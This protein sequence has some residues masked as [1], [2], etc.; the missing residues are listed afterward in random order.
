MDL[1]LAQSS[2]LSSRTAEGCLAPWQAPPDVGRL[3]SVD[4]PFLLSTA[5][6][7][8]YEVSEPQLLCWLPLTFAVCSHC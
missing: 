4:C 2:G 3:Q 1:W 8:S 6:G 5:Q 7:C